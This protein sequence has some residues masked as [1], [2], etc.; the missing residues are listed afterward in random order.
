MA[1]AGDAEQDGQHDESVVSGEENDEEE[2]LKRHGNIINGGLGSA[3][4]CG[5]ADALG[6]QSDF[7][8]EAQPL[9]GEFGNYGLTDSP[10]QKS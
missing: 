10:F 4:Q 9:L 3:V 6:S 2:N 1:G 7:F 8:K 5:T